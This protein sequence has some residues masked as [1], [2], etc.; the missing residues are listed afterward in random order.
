MADF[1][2][3]GIG[4]SAGGLKALER[5]FGAMPPDSGLGFVV[6]AH[7]DPTQESHLSE[8]LRRDTEMPV[9][10]VRGEIAVQPNHVY[11]IAPDQ[12]LRL[13]GDVLHPSKP[14][15]PRGHRHPV[16]TLFRSLA[17]SSG[18]RA[19]GIV[20]SGTGTDGA[21]GLRAIKAEGGITLAQDPGTA[22]FAG[23]PQSAITTGAADLVLAPEKMA[24]A[25]LDL[26]SHPYLRRDV[27]LGKPP[28][29]DGQLTALLALVRAGTRQDFR[30]Y[31]R[32]TLLRRIHRRMGLKQVMG[33]D[34]YIERLRNDPDELAA[35]ARDL[36]IIVSGFFRDPEAWKVLDQKV[37]APLIEE[38]P[39][40]AAIRV[41]VPACATGEEAYSIAMLVVERAEAAQKSF[42]LK[43]FATDVSEHLL[44]AA[45]AGLYPAS[46]AQNVSKERLERF[47]DRE[48]DS[49][50][51][52]GALRDAITWAPQNLMQDPPF[53]RLDVVSCRNLLIYLEPEIQKKLLGLFHFALREGG[54]LFL[55]SAETAAAQ[56]NLFQPISKKWRIYLRLGPTRHDV[57]EF[58][59]LRPSDDPNAAASA[60]AAPH[61]EPRAR[62][63]TLLEHALLEQYAPAAVLID[64]RFNVSEFHGPTG[65]YLQ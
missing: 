33:L 9:A 10:D 50:R 48:D 65:D 44:P 58:P 31:K 51:V 35:L 17:E 4:S 61:A 12:Y 63:S 62:A 43:I 27:D 57:T 52:K 54:H 64:R 3:V 56:A 34:D 59:I 32:T 19:I 29:I 36:T 40:D 16:D 24:A 2:I 38:R 30:C 28:E 60:P 13:N 15:E 41:W 25:L 6:V 5:L 49:Y 11:V 8:L 22:D 47:F 53:S 18:K 45:R 14:S 23:M 20:L 42:D 55:G 21:D 26:T 39:A 7:L 46:I 37:I 1:P